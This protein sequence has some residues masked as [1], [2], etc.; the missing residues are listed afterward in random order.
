MLNLSIYSNRNLTRH[1]MYTKNDIVGLSP[2]NHCL[3]HSLNPFYI[4]K[5]IYVL[6]LYEKYFKYD[7]SQFPTKLNALHFV[8]FLNTCRVKFC[9][10]NVEWIYGLRCVQLYR[11]ISPWDGGKQ[12]IWHTFTVLEFLYGRC[13]LINWYNRHNKYQYSLYV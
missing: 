4:I 8:L 7:K 9:F 1:W 3:T 12:L 6:Y 5:K 10:D 11:S 2:V 13:W